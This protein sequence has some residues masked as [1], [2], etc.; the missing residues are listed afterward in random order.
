MNEI[1]TDEV[2]WK[3]KKWAV[4]TT[5]LES[6]YYSEY[7]IEKSQL[8]DG[9]KIGSTWNWVDQIYTKTWADPHLFLLAYIKAIAFHKPDAFCDLVFLLFLDKALTKVNTTK[10]NLKHTNTSDGLQFVTAAELLKK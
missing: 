4:T 8:L 6:I 10:K 9:I 1:K 2:L 7:V 3:N 5:G